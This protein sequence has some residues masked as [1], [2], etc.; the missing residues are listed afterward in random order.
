MAEDA[1]PRGTT[2]LDGFRVLWVGVRREPRVF[3]IATL[4]AVLFGVLTVA[5][6]WVLGW[7]TQNV[8]IPAFDTGEI[9]TDMLVWV[10]VLFMSVAILRA[11]GIVARPPG[12]SSPTPTP[13]SRPHGRR[14]RRCRW[15]SAPS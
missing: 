15:R 10:F 9:G 12:S 1:E 4:G 5:D 2:T 8:L 7:S 6:A 13:T 11:I 14:S 3:T